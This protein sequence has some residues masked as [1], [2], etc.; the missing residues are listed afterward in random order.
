MPR[1]RRSTTTATIEQQAMADSR[2]DDLNGYGPE[3]PDDGYAPE[4]AQAQLPG[5]PMP[6][7]PI[8]PE[9]IHLLA[10]EIRE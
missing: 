6:R 10:I 9:R 3:V 5:T 2:L 4:L 7:R 1:G 8:A